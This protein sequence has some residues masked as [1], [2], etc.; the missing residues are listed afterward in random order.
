MY[1]L[2]IIYSIAVCNGHQTIVRLLLD[3]MTNNNNDYNDKNNGNDYS[4]E[5]DK[6]RSSS[7]SNSVRTDCNDAIV[8]VDIDDDNDI[9]VDAT[10]TNSR[11]SSNSRVKS[12]LFNFRIVKSIRKK[13]H[14]NNNNN[15]NMVHGD[16]N[17]NGDTTT[18]IALT[19]PPPTTTTTTKRLDYPICVTPLMLACYYGKLS[20]VKELL[21][22]RFDSLSVDSESNSLLHYLS[23]CRHKDYLD[24]IHGKYSN[25]VVECHIVVEKLKI[26]YVK[27]LL[28]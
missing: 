27:C 22:R 12:Y 14:N 7:S 16:D 28:I 3:L 9:N 8:L 1:F 19:P 6:K 15:N 20:I 26:S 25:I 4:G 18:T 17:N 11:S 13:N 23:R 2:I 5:I 24:I 21:W 10:S